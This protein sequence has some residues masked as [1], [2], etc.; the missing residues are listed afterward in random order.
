MNNFPKNF[1]SVWLFGT[2]MLGVQSCN[3]QSVPLEK[4]KVQFT[5]STDA[6]PDGRAQDIN[7]PEGARLR[8]S[9]NSSS[10]K[11]IFSNKE[12]QLSKAGSD[13]MADPLELM[14]GTYMITDFM[15]VSDS[16]VL[17]A[18]P[19]TKSSFGPLVNHS[20]PYNFSVTE[21][22]VANV[23]MQVIDARNEKPEAFGYASFKVNKHNKLSFMVS[24][25]KG[26]HTLKEATAELRRG[27]DLI[28]TYTVKPGINTI[29]FEG[30]PDTVYTLSVFAGEMAQA[31]TFNF[32]ELKKELGTKPMQITLEPALL[33][34]MESSFDESDGWE[35]FFEFV[36]E[37]TGG[38]VN[39]NWGDGYQ[40]SYTL[41]LNGEHQYTSGS[42]TAIIT[43]DLDQITNLYGFAYSTYI[44][45]I[46]GLTN[47]TALKTYDPSWGAIPI[48]VDLSNCKK[49]ETIF[50]E[51]IG[52]PYETVDLLTE[53]RLP[54]EHFIKEFVFYAPSLDP[55]RENIT[56]EEL[57]MFVDNI[58]NN[59]TRRNIYDGKFFVYPIDAPSAETQR[60]LDILQNEYH[61]D[62]RFDGNIWDDN[63]EAGRTKQDLNARR[64]NW[65]RGKFPDYKRIWRSTRMA[66][67][68]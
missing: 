12:I 16:D 1:I 15:I 47:L 6:S 29:A 34:T 50:I 41:P 7:L 37:G 13:Y 58:Y 10:G 44:H 56:A 18:A 36:L 53:F 27:K 26:G 17:N 2:L 57:E 42:Y 24:K 35:D 68:N 30:E 3:E 52:G 9:I 59:T 5:L 67:A 33:L 65:L 45:A 8:I 46:K 49:L 38:A 62:V 39:V 64:E 4:S 61:W 66:R 28:K 20:L 19:K 48:K 14:P 54:K 63:F 32:K 23:S 31:K 25:K 11:P 55:T 22:G 40:D 51:K 60:K 43:G 21:N